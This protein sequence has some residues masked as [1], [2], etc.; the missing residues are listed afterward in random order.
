MTRHV[1]FALALAACNTQ[2]LTSLPEGVFVITDATEYQVT[3][4]PRA[5]VVTVQNR[6]PAPIPVLRCLFR[7]SATDPIGVDLCRQHEVEGAWHPFAL[8]FSC[9]T[10]SDAPRADVVVA[11]MDSTQVARIIVITP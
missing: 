9:L 11:P 7:G 2:P 8:G 10:A 1:L 4:P 5:T 3:S 6:T